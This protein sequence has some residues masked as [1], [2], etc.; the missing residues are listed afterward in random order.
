[1]SLQWRLKILMAIRDVSAKKLSQDSGLSYS[2]VV[3]LRNTMP[4][5]IDADTLEKLC[6]ALKCQPGDL[7]QW[8][9]DNDAA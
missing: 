5:R 4:S 9:P 2:T 6:A 7:L 3:K 8:A 1:M